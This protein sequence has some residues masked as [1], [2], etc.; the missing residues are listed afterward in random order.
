MTNLVS[1]VI[2]THNEAK[3]ILELYSRLSAVA[4]ASEYLFEFIFVDD[5]TDQTPNLIMELRKADSRIRLLRLTR[6]FGQTAAIQAGLDVAVGQ[7]VVMMD[8]DLQDPPETIALFLEKW[9]LGYK[10]VYATRPSQ[11]T[12]SYRVASAIFYELLARLSSTKIPRNAGEFRLLDRT[13]V[14]L[15]NSMPD[16]TRFMRGLTMWSG[17]QSIGVQVLRSERYLGS[18]NYNFRRSL[19]VAIDGLVGHSLAPLRL[20]PLVGIAMLAMAFLAAGSL[21]VASLLG[22]AGLGAP[23]APIVLAI[24]TIGGLNIFMMG[25]VAEYLGKIFRSIQDRPHYIVLEDSNLKQQRG[26]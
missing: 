20:V 24:A 26:E 14:N 1:I 18:S 11:G 25:I 9:E 2:P 3:N 8:A 22:Y 19:S 4:S 16:K 6:S 13:V 17:H 10:V 5:S 23:W 15:V 7:A 21:L 12:W